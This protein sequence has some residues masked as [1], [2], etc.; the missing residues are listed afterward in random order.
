MERGRR[1]A[2]CPVWRGG[3]EGE[4]SRKKMVEKKI[5]ASEKGGDL[6]VGVCVVKRRGMSNVE[7]TRGIKIR[8][9][10]EQGG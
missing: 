10:G 1:G 6:N 5:G 8:K 7:R 4:Q 9:G 2:R 3:V